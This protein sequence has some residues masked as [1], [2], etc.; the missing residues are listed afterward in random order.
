MSSELLSLINDLKTY[1][2]M[3]TDIQP[4]ALGFIIDYKRFVCTLENIN[5]MVGLNTIKN[6][7]ADQVKS[8][9]VEYR[10]CGNPTNGQKL[11]TL[12]YGPPGCGKTQIGEYLSELWASSGCLPPANK[13]DR[14]FHHQPEISGSL[15]PKLNLKSDDNKLF[16]D[17]EKVSLRQ[18]LAIQS[19]QLRQCQQ[20]IQ[21]TTVVINGILTQF[22]NVRKKVKSKVPDHEGHIQ[23]KFQE[24]KKN[25]REITGGAVV[26]TN[27]TNQDLIKLCNTPIGKSAPE[28]LPVTVPKIPG[29]RSMFGN[30]HPPLL[31]Q[32]PS[33]LDAN[34]ILSQ[35]ASIIKTEAPAE[36]PKPLAK[37]TRLTKG[38]LVGK[39]QG[40]TTDQV[41]KVLLEH[42][43]GVVMIDEAY[44]L[45]T[46]AQDDFGKEALTEINN[47]MDTWPD[48]IIFIFA[49]Y[50]KDIE[51]GILKIQP[52]LD[53]RFNW[54]FEINEYSPQELNLIFQQ[55]LKTRLALS[56]GDET[57]KR[58]EDFFK[59]NA[60]KFPH[61]GGDTERLCDT[62]KETFNKQNW[63]IALDD[64][65][66]QE[67]FNKLFTTINFDCIQASF[68]KYLDNSVKAKEEEDKKRKE[69]KDR[70]LY[71]HIY[72]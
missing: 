48:K 68:D 61:Y 4:H 70:K 66:S 55:Q 43:G 11:H 46:S 9:I 64:N 21:T 28:I 41:R 42:V 18:N 34:N 13:N 24:I 65:I 51:E 69:E 67:D 37:F 5:N 60:S 40:H 35:L 36:P 57:L 1:K 20:K 71:G 47:F 38:D 10:K 29:H 8:F 32:V 26:V 62:V 7:I 15:A 53:R 50:R 25:L 39:F 63:K 27:S 54:T 14:L 59:N 17:T 45:C 49:G 19:A 23:A 2:P 6:Q 56:P 22:N 12:L 31:P 44:N 72:S 58:L 30:S 16:H 33:I 3:G 52:G